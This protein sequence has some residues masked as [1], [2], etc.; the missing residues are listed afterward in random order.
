MIIS[1]GQDKINVCFIFKN[2]IIKS[3]KS[4][5]CKLDRICS[6]CFDSISCFFRNPFCHTARKTENRMNSLSANICH[7]ITA[8]LPDSNN[9]FGNIHANLFDNTE[10]IPFPGRSI[11]TNYKIRTSKIIKVNRVIFKHKQ[12]IKE[13]TNSLCSWGGFYFE[14]GIQGFCAC[15]VMSSGANTTDTRSYL[16]HIFC[17]SSHTKS[18][19]ST[20]FRYLEKSSFHITLIIEDNCYFTM[21]FQSGDWINSYNLIHLYPPCELYQA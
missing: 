17:R 15:H 2:D 5:F 9:L 4:E 1:I 3:F 11:G 18:F 7:N 12:I 10:N 8:A 21:T 14:K 16:R 20:K 6:E 19:E 13:F